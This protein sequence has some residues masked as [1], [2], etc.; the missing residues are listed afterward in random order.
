MAYI[1]KIVN[2]VNDKVYVGK[3]EFSLEK[4]FREHCNDADKRDKEQRPLYTAMKKYGIEHFHIELIE[5]TDIPAEREVYWIEKLEGYTKGY[6]ATI[7]GDGT[8]YIDYDAVVALYQEVQNQREVARQIGISVDSV[9]H[10]LTEKNIETRTSG[11]I[12]K[13]QSQ[14]VVEMRL[15]NQPEVIAIFFSYAEAA[16]YVYQNG[17]STSKRIEGIS[18]HIR[19]VCLGR[20]KT[21]YGFHWSVKN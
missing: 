11:D 9:K 2:D 5:E 14:K 19:D 3:T 6:N 1:Y 12:A 10:I 8:K 13:E 17:I 4:R 20:R 18:T 7:G 16:R 15:P 21:A